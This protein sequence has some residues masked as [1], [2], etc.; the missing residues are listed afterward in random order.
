[1]RRLRY[2]VAHILTGRY[3]F[4]VYEERLM[5]NEDFD[6][7][8]VFL[9]KMIEAN[10]AEGKYLDA[11][12]ILVKLKSTYD[13]ETDKAVIEKELRES[14]FEYHYQTVVHTNNTD[15]DKTRNNNEAQYH[16]EKERNDG[17]T[18][19][20]TRRREYDSIDRLI[21]RGNFDLP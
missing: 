10:P 17:K 18:H 7:C 12:L 4:V 13:L 16:T 20:Y 11:Y 2:C 6:K 1:M 3:D 15:Y 9:E 8:R 14:E 5:N 19:R 21:N